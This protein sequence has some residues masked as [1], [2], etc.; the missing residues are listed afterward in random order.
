[1][2]RETALADLSTLSDQEAQILNNSPELLSKFQA[3]HGINQGAS[4]LGINSQ[5]LPQTISA[6]ARPALEMGGAVGGAALASPGIATTPIG[7]ALGFAAGKS[8]AD[9]LDRMMGIKQ[10]LQNLQQAASETGQNIK[11]GAES[12]LAGQ[13]GGAALGAMKKPVS[14]FFGNLGRIQSGVKP[15]IGQRL[16][17]QPEAYFSPSLSTSGKELGAVR[18]QMGMQSTPSIDEII[19]TEAT[20]ARNTAKEMYEKLQNKTFSSADLLKGAQSVDDVIEATPVKQVNKRRMLFGLKREFTD[21]LNSVAPEERQK[22]AQ[23]SKSAIADEFRKFFPV[24]KQGDVSVLRTLGLGAMGE[25]GRAA[26]V[27]PSILQSPAI[28]GTGIASAGALYKAMSNPEI[29]RAV[30]AQIRGQFSQ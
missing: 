13:I 26:A 23:Y 2:S 24:T 8:G 5:N 10:P 1:M 18:S 22:A 7:G 27:I 4:F 28:A 15:E 9:L 3:K 21:A 30:L 11:Q 19:D 17:N 20:T 25:G 16:F 14:K 29:R 6:F 12:E